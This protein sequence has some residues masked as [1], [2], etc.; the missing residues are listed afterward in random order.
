MRVRKDKTSD[1]RSKV[2]PKRKPGKPKGK[3]AEA[4]SKGMKIRKRLT[5]V[6]LENLDS[7]LDAQ[8][9]LAKGTHVMVARA[10]VKNRAGER[11]RTGEWKEVRSKKEIA[12]LLNGAKEGDEYYQ[13][14]TKIPSQR[15]AGYL[16]DQAAG[17]AP[18]PVELSG[19]VTSIVELIQ[20]L[21][22]D[23]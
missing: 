1:G 13:I 4:T 19:E 7:V 5:E 18:Q 14:W 21:E 22:E 9:E 12:E 17:K 16:I 10:W 23:D 20:T 15:A 8:L 11:H 3:I 2:M 6:V